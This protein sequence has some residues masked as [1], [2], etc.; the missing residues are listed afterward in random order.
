MQPRSGVRSL[1][2]W[3][4]ERALAS[5]LPLPSLLDPA[6]ERLQERD[7]RLL[8]E[9]VRG[10]LR[11]LRRLDGVLEQA[12]ERR[13]DSIQRELLAPLRVG[14]YQ[15]LFLDRVPAHAVVAEA[16]EDARFRVHRGAAGL[17]NA[18]L[19][20]IARTRDLVEWPIEETDPVRRLAIESSHPDVLVERWLERYG[21]AETRAL[22][23]A[24]NRVKPMAL[25][26]FRDLGGRELLAERLIDEGLEVEAS[27]L[28]PFGLVV[29]KGRPLATR[30][31]AEGLFYVQDE[32]SQAVA[33]VPRPRV[34]ERILDVASGPGGK[35]WS[36]VSF[37]PSVQLFAA[38][39]SL[40]RLALL[41][42]NRARLG[43][44]GPTLVAD[45]TAG[46]WRPV[47]DR[48][49]V[50]APCSG[51]GTLRKHPELKWRFSLEELMRLAAASRQLLAGAARAV[52]PG[53]ILCW[54]TCSLEAEE[55]EQV[56]EWFLA[57]HPDF[58]LLDLA[59]WVLPAHRQG[60]RGPGLWRLLPAGDHDGFSAVIFERAC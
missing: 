20:R 28:A 30:S 16:V 3:V 58:S 33:L 18:V 7:R 14:A 41:V 46:A 1:A 10:T 37:E 59:D 23:E 50:D 31:F 24:N 49:V 6:G 36:L 26:A 27:A 52:A 4:V 44:P 17:V 32:G 9:L 34:G 2:A 45:G 60:V 21:E 39:G 38:D 55:N 51:T 29:R 13:L 47:F 54:I 42:R 53:G 22:L 8:G 5:K 57:E 40:E 56:A 15:L 19:R 35:G 48:V 43:R 12:A 25:L 11:W